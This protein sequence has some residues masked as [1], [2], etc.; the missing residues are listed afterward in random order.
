MVRLTILLLGLAPLS[1]L[2]SGPNFSR[3]GLLFGLQYGFGSWGYDRAR[4]EQQVGP[5]DAAI[6]L[7][8]LKNTHTA[9]LKLGYNILGHAT[10]G[11]DFT[12]TG[13]NVFDASRGGAGFLVGS[14]RWHPLELVWLEKDRPVPLDA[15]LFAGLG[16]GIVGQRRGMD[17]MVWEVGFEAEYY[18]NRLLSLGLFAR[19][20]LPQW[21]ALYIDYDNR[22]T[23]PLDGG[24]SGNFWSY[25]M[26]ATFRFE[27]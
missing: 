5:G 1:A 3:G 9:T 21:N 23:V 7:D 26:M 22:I 17:G 13:W 25:G 10:V 12:A 4:L 18:L 16:Y 11:A 24:W 15:S 20:V 19:G 6:F 8:D 2:A 14:V 27:P